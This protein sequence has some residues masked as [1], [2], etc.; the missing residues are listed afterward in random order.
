[1][2]VCVCMRVCIFVYTHKHARTPINTHTCTHIF[3]GVLILPFFFLP[4]FPSLSHTHT[5]TFPLHVS[6]FVI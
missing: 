6:V 4:F 2:S 5:R 3:S 1:M